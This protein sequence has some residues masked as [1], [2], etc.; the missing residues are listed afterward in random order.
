MDLAFHS[1]SS[2]N[3]YG[4]SNE[5]LESISLMCLCI[6]PSVC[7]NQSLFTPSRSSSYLPLERRS[8]LF[9]IL[10]PPS[11]LHLLISSSPLAS[12]PSFYFLL[13]GCNLVRKC[14]CRS[15]ALRGDGVVEAVAMETQH[16]WNVED[17]SSSSSVLVLCSGFSSSPVWRRDQPV[18]PASWLCHLVARWVL[19]SSVCLHHFPKNTNK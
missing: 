10:F 15:D 11:S 4:R 9:S 5:L 2:N 14:A 1:L 12:F 3:L 16:W 17:S 6:Q 7:F 19:S 8:L 18:P 13:C